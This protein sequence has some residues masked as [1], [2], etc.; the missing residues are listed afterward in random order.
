MEVSADVVLR[1]LIAMR[2]CSRHVERGTGDHP[3]DRVDIGILTLAAE[4]GGQLRPSQ[5]AGHLDVS[6]PSITRHV[7]ALQQRGH[8]STH[9]DPSDHRGYRIAITAAGQRMLGAFRQDLVAR[10]AP[11]LDGWAAAD[12][13]T[14]ADGLT[15][16]NAAMDEALE[17]RSRRAGTRA[18]WR[19]NAAPE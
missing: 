13:E 11:A 15:K 1:L 18:W 5:A 9:P 3:L 17:T 10:F 2:D 19:S 8:V 12:V 6:Q 7:R 16:L 4:T 14:L